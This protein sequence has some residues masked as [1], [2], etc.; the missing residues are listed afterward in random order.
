MWYEKFAED[1]PKAY[2]FVWM[3]LDSQV[4]ASQL[5]QTVTEARIGGGPSTFKVSS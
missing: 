2:S 4:Q 5:H 3:K 1:G